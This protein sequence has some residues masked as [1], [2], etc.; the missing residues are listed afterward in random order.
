M[1]ID[2]D[3]QAIAEILRQYKHIAVVGLTAKSGRPSLQVAEYLQGQGYDIIPIN[4]IYAGRTILQRPVYASLAEAQAAGETIE[5][6]DVFR[7][8]E[9]TPAVA[10]E[11]VQAGAKV[12]WLQLGITNEEA[13]DIAHVAGL[14]Y[15]EDR[16]IKIEHARLL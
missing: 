4:P 11:T 9:L 12:L 10:Q 13:A 2:V 6:V 14:T 7:R 15:V 5:V 1:A 3:D 8:S 16:C